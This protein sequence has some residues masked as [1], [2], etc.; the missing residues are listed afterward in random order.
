MSALDLPR[1]N[2]GVSIPKRR[3]WKSTTHSFSFTPST[4]QNFSVGQLSPLQANDRLE[5]LL[6]TLP[7]F[8]K[9]G[10]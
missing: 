7:I 10:R 1:Q 3:T 5:D 9:L 8:R 6:T 2:H 4:D